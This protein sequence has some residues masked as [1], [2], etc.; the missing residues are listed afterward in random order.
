M[1]DRVIDQD[2]TWTPKSVSILQSGS[3]GSRSGATA[4]IAVGGEGQTGVKVFKYSYG[5]CW[6]SNSDRVILQC[7]H[8]SDAFKFVGFSPARLNTI[9][10]VMV[11]GVTTGNRV[12]CWEIRERQSGMQDNRPFWSIDS[13][14]TPSE[15]V[16]LFIQDVL[17][18]NSHDT[19]TPGQHNF[20]L[21][22]SISN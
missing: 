16:S 18:C 1:Y 8:N 19:V 21:D 4:W 14:K 3:V 20:G 9:E 5:N 7:P 17:N 22:S 11:Y 12:H 13:N 6:G 10:R 15:A 2:E